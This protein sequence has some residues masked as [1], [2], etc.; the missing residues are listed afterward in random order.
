MKYFIS[1]N[2][3]KDGPFTYEEVLQKNLSPDVL[4]WKQEQSWWLPINQVEEFKTHIEQRPAQTSKSYGD[5]NV[6]VISC[7]AMILILFFM[8][9]AKKEQLHNKNETVITEDLKD[10]E[11]LV[12]NEDIFNQEKEDLDTSEN[13]I[14]S[15]LGEEA[16]L[17]QK[18]IRE[19]ADLLGVGT[20]WGANKNRFTQS[21]SIQ[22][23]RGLEDYRDYISSPV[24]GQNLDNLKKSNK[25]GKK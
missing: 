10:D 20:G 14:H 1:I 12:E 19:N 21:N 8:L 4:I 2:N 23:G 25:S 11:P 3:K 18:R 17:R 9:V 6:F 13:L 16:S 5:Y 24:K 7:V 22:N 15:P